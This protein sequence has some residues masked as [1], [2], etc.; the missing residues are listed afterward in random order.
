MPGQFDLWNA[1]ET[2]GNKQYWGGYQ[3]VDGDGL[4][5][6]FVVRRGDETGQMI[7][8]NTVMV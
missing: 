2:G 7:A 3:D 5:H 1:K 4:A 8:V 6:E